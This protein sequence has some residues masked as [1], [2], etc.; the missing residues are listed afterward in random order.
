[1]LDTTEYADNNNNGVFD[2]GDLTG[3]LK[4]DNSSNDGVFSGTGIDRELTGL[5]D[6]YYNADEGVVEVSS[7]EAAAVRSLSQASLSQQAMVS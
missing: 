1:M 2:I 4:I 5:F 7:M 6:A 3:K